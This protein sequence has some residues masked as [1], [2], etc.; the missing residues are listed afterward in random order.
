MASLI[1]V[2]SDAV[3]RGQRGPLNNSDGAPPQA[4]NPMPPHWKFSFEGS[5]PYAT[6]LAFVFKLLCL[7]SFGSR[8]LDEL[9]SKMGDGEDSDRFISYKDRLISKVSIVTIVVCWL[10]PFLILVLI[11]WSAGRLASWHYHVI[12]DCTSAGTS[13]GKLGYSSSV[14]SYP[15]LFRLELWLS[16][17][18]FWVGVLHYSMHGRLVPGCKYV[19][20]FRLLYNCNPNIQ[21][22]FSSRRRLFC[23][24][25]VLA[26]PFM[27]LLLAIIINAVGMSCQLSS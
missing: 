13:A 18:G 20:R 1:P 5:R 15:H 2:P 27:T 22:L 11:I 10:R 24:M 16:P 25:F 23:T 6:S 17:R 21:T 7:L 8:N 4:R 12:G 26:Y 19:I 9:W 3:S 14:Y